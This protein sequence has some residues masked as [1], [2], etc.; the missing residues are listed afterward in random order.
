[1]AARVPWPMWPMARVAHCLRG[2]W[3]AWLVAHG[4]WPV[5]CG[6]HYVHGS[7]MAMDIASAIDIQGRAHRT[8]GGSACSDLEPLRQI[9]IF[10]WATWGFVMYSGSFDLVTLRRR[11]L[12]CPA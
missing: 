12:H 5:A 6:Q 11:S 3:P 4:T 2:P 7:A 9:G 8:H 10:Y 1:M